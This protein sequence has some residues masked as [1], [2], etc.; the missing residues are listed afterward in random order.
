[1]LS[2]ILLYSKVTQIHIYTYIYSHTLFFI[3]FSITVYPK[4]LDIVP[5]YQAFHI[6]LYQFFFQHFILKCLYSVLTSF[7]WSSLQHFYTFFNPSTDHSSSSL[8]LLFIG[9]TCDTWKYLGQGSKSELQLQNHAI[10]MATR[11]LRHICDLCREAGSLSHQAR[12]GTE[13]T[14]SQRQQWVLNLLNHI[15]NSLTLPLTSFSV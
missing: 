10:T 5:M 12:K 6:F 2:Q 13:P 3:S 7:Y 1:M 15:G 9:H 8:P 11:E 4:R 14:S